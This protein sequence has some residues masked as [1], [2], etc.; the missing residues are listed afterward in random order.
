MVPVHDCSRLSNAEKL[1]YLQQALKGGTAK[2]TIE[3]LSRSS[4]NYDE[5]IQRLK[6]RYDWPRLIHQTHVKAIL[7]AKDGTGREIRKLHDTVLQHLRAL[8]SMGHDP[9]G[10]FITSTLE[11]K[12]DQT[13]MFEWQKHSLKSESI[14]PY[15]DLIEFLNLRAQATESSLVEPVP[16]RG[17]HE[18]HENLVAVVIYSLVQQMRGLVLIDV[19]HVR[20]KGIRYTQGY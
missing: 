15:Q 10:P 2:N 13:T 18:P 12:L 17:R 14:P 8:K 19:L 11:L 6:A 3:G 1:V 9:S 4:D 5:A 16:K 20:Q 7:E